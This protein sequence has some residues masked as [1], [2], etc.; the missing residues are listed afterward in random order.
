MNDEGKI[1]GLI[2]NIQ[3]F[4]VHDGP[5]IRTTVF[6]KGCPL[7]CIW[8]ANP[9]S[10]NP[11][12]EI[13]FNEDKCIKCDKCLYI[14][15]K[16]AITKRSNIIVIDRNKC[17][18]CG[19]CVDVCYSSAL[20]LCG[21]YL[22][23]D[24]VLSEIEKDIPFY[25]ASNGGVTV[26]GGEPLMQQNFLTRLFV[27]AHEKGIHTALE[28]SGYASWK[29]FHRILQHTDLVL[30]DL[31]TISPKIHKEMTGV[32][33]ELILKNLERI[34]RER[35]PTIIRIPIIPG[36]NIVNE[37]DIHGMLKFVV[38]LKGI[39]RID[40]LPYHSLGEI[41]YRWLGKPYQV[42]TNPPGKEFM[43]KLKETVESYGFK[44]SIGGIL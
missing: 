11:F 9:E 21:R 5:G 39:E 42:K 13:M 34:C 29:V 44:T 6:F 31:K 3:R 17:D 38:R 8:C 25:D 4:S 1:K 7:Q 22:S 14:C 24:D 43:N 32:T 16:G 35:F 10:I 26:S 36:Y 2:F 27:G 30:Y 41:K 28:T 15:P 37:K 20:S 19:K 18:G 12:P 23:L 40:L 33:N